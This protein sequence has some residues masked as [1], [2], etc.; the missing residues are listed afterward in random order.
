M[1]FSCISIIVGTVKRQAQKSPPSG[2]I[3]LAGISF[4]LLLL[5][6]VG[7]AA[8]AVSA[9]L[10]EKEIKSLI[11]MLKA[12]D[13]LGI[14]RF[15]E[16]GSPRD[17]TMAV[18]IAANRDTILNIFRD[19][20]NFY[21]VST[22]FKENTVLDEHENAMVWSWA[23]RHKI[24]SVTGRNSLV[25]YPPRRVD[26]T[27]EESSVGKGTY[28]FQFYPDGK[29]HT[30]M[31]FSGFLDV[32]SSEWLIRFLVG[33]NPSMKQAMN[34][35]IGLVVLKGVK[36]LAERMEKKKPNRPHQT[37]GESGGPPRLLSDEEMATLKPLLTRGQI[38]LCDSHKGGR[39]SQVSVVDIA[40]TSEMAFRQA[41]ANPHNYA[42][43]IGAISNIQVQ[44]ESAEKT[45]FSWTIGLSIFGLNSVN[46][47]SPTSDGV[48]LNAVSG[49]LEGAVWRW[50]TAALGNHRTLVAYHAFADVGKMSAILQTT[51]KREPYLEHGLVLG[52]NIVMVK[53]MKKIVENT[54]KGSH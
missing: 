35:A 40:D 37:G 29:D 10:D 53:A 39:L 3:S 26:V 31:I 45:T 1:T 47:L 38:F 27:I 34:I 19:P 5:V 44:Q 46:E 22:L 18:R 54:D 32:N 42:K 17:V 30:I 25:M 13:A 8:A 4:V 28:T 2:W 20:D 23:S 24:L 41:A 49:D 43:Y 7:A 48:A 51:V 12:H 36:D 16:K 14:T 50:Q 15:D 11:P 6:P 21:F 33:D 52:S 9:P